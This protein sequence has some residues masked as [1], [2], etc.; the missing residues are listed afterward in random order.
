MSSA[1]RPAAGR[2]RSAARHW[3]AGRYTPGGR[4]A[5]RQ[6][7]QDLAAQP[8]AHPEPA[9]VPR[10]GQ[11]VPPRPASSSATCPCCPPSTTCTGCSRGVEHVV[12]LQS[13][14]QLYLGSGGDRRSA[15]ERGLRTVVTT[16]NGQL[17]P[18]QIRDRSVDV[19]VPVAERA[20]PGNPL[21]VGVAVRRRGHP[22]G[23][24][25]RRGAGR[26]HGRHHRGDEDGGLD[27]RAAGRAGAADRDQPRCSRWRAATCCSC[28]PTSA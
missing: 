28:S 5:E 15:D 7:A 3:P 12:D 18:L 22:G 16:L 24:R 8:A 21:H 10:P 13:G 23:G 20:D 26:G 4:R 14:V 19:D 2:S 25:G 9:A 1:T 17:R 27:H 11:G 6:D